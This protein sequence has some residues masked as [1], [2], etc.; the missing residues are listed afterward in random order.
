MDFEVL[1]W[2][3]G[4]PDLNPIENIW[5]LMALKVYE[6]GRQLDCVYDLK[7]ELKKAW[8][9]IQGKVLH[10]L[11]LSVPRRLVSVIE[12]RGKILDY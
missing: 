5:A 4:S 10:N 8:I 3:A 7:E 2:P 11:V 12:A 6:N 9:E 1:V